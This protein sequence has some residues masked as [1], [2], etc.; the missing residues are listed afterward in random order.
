[1]EGF[2][3]IV[4][5][6]VVLTIW[7]I[8]RSNKDIKKY[9]KQKNERLRNDC[10]NHE[11]KLDH[12]SGYP[13]AS[14]FNLF[15]I[16]KD[17]TC[18]ITSYASID[19]KN[20]GDYY[21]KGISHQIPVENILRIESKTEEEIQK[22]ITIPRILLGGILALAKPKKTEIKRQYLYL[23]YI[24]SG[25]QID[26]LFEG[27]PNENLGRLTSLVNQLRIEKNRG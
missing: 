24:D 17:K 23:S 2:M 3:T 25:V 15:Q 19:L 11:F 9:D 13:Y 1:M 21:G 14:T 8:W 5:I 12:I 7:I 27:Y 16:K 26:C 22:D 20:G 6:L 10:V 4:V 18:Y